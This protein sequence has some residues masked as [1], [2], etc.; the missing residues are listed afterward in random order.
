[1]LAEKVPRYQIETPML[2]AAK[3]GIAEI[4]DKLLE[5]YPISI[6]DMDSEGKNAVL[7]AVEHRHTQVYEKLISRK[8]LDDRAFRNPQTQIKYKNI[9]QD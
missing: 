3:N 6:L 5:C 8:F 2:V 4:V 7:L 9:L 1:M